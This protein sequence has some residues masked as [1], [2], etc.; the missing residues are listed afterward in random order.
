MKPFITGLVAG[1][2]I[3]IPVGAIAI[4][5]INISLR[6]GF[7]PGLMAAAGAAS[8]DFIYALLATLAGNQIATSLAPFTIALRAVS[9]LVL[10]LIGGYGLLRARANS[11]LTDRTTETFAGGLRTYLQFLGLTLLNPLTVAYFGALIIG[12]TLNGLDTALGRIL[13][14]MGA[15]IASFSWQSFLVVAGS[16]GHR[17]LT[18]R[19]QGLT[20]L[21]G[22]T[23]VI[24][25]GI[26]ILVQVST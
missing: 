11:T 21:I 9:G 12:S 7:R 19:M 2:G 8:A 20:H 26:R 5:I 16:F 4:L 23:I 18:P 14:V 6:A 22:N 3:A 25:F 1:Y 13:F 24:G 17:R 15:G 10:I